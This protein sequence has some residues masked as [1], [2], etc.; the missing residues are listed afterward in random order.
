LANQLAGEARQLVSKTPGTT[1][2]A[3]DI[4]I[5]QGG[6]TCLLVDTP[7][8]RRKRSI[9]QKLEQMSVMAAIRSLERADVGLVVLDGSVDFAVQDARLLRLVQERGRGLMVLVNKIDLWDKRRQ[10]LYLKELKHGMRFVSWAPVLRVSARTGAGVK[11]IVPEAKRVLRSNQERIST[12][13]LNRFVEEAASRLQP[14]LIRGK[15]ARIYYITQISVGP[16]TF[17][18]WVNDPS[19]VPRNYQRYLEGRLR[20]RF[21]FPGTPLRWK[22]KKRQGDRHKPAKKTRKK[23][24]GKGRRKR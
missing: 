7:G 19:R 4:V 6:T 14:P 17:V 20:K 5:E 13:D 16:P 21:P 18:A 1:R 15:R 10:E 3:V 23:S 24:K 2:D 12:S 11:R 8:V 9:T 22:F